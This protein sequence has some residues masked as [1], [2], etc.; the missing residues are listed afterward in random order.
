MFTWKFKRK[1]KQ[2]ASLSRRGKL[3]VLK[4]DV[5]I[6]PILGKELLESMY[7]SEPQLGQDGKKYEIDDITRISKAQGELLYNLCCDVK[8]DVSLEVGLA[9]GFST[10]FILSAL[11]KIGSG[12]HIAIDPIQSVYWNGIGAAIAGRLNMKDR[13][14]LIEDYAEYVFPKLIAEQRKSQFIY[15]DGD[16]KFDSVMLDF[17]L[18]SRMCSLG[19]VIILDDMWMTSIRRLVSFI[20]SNRPD[21]SRL[22]SYVENIAIFTRIATNDKRNWDH[23][24]EF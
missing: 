2:R 10:A 4:S 8:P 14:T 6:P 18:A 17:T 13:F 20:E 16:H 24:V 19:G 7:A 21:F 22:K 9:Y 1:I 3:G 12:H 11:Y 23:F 5:D 15:I